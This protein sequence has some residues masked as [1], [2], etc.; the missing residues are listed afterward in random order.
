MGLTDWNRSLVI[1]ETIIPRMQ[2]PP[3]S[4][5]LNND[6]RLQAMNHQLAELHQ[7]MD[8]TNAEANARAI[9]RD[10]LNH[11]PDDYMLHENY[12]EFL[13]YIG[14]NQQ[15]ASEWQQACRAVTVQC[16]RFLP[17]RPGAGATGSIR[18][19]ASRPVKGHLP[20]SPVL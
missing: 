6:Q 8:A 4:T 10:A 16:F 18:G 19:G 11:A 9:Y 1:Q 12:A 3:L 5:Q 17:G 7:R 20:A 13:Q 2:Q 14:D 15:S